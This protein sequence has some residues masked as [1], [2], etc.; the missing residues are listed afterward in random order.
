MH[1][2]LPEKLFRSWEVEIPLNK[3]QEALMLG[4]G[5]EFPKL[6]EKAHAKR[7][8]EFLAGRYCVDKTLKNFGVRAYSPIP[9]QTS[10]APLWP[11][12]YIGSIAHT[13]V[14]AWAVLAKQEQVKFIGNDMELLMPMD[15]AENIQS[16]IISARE[17]EDFHTDYQKINFEVYLTL[18]FSAKESLYKALFPLVG[19]FFGFEDAVVHSIDFEKKI[20]QLKLLKKLNKKYRENSLYKVYFSIEED[21]I[22]TM[23]LEAK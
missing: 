19:E 9:T 22:R 10:R 1:S 13:K 16:K 3:E 2:G 23:I 17:L 4:Q 18:V 8:A 15:T 6:L 20:L 11:N 12:G 5:F 21:S 7:L 14:R